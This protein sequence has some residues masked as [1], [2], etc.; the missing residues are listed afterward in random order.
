MRPRWTQM[1]SPRS[2]V[3]LFV[4]TI[5]VWLL[6]GMESAGR[7]KKK[8]ASKVQ[9][10]AANGQSAPP[11]SDEH[12]SAEA[13]ASQAV[14]QTPSGKPSQTDRGSADHGPP[15]GPGAAASLA[16]SGTVTVL[17]PV[18]GGVF[19]SPE[20]ELKLNVQ[21]L[22]GNTLL[23]LKVLVDGRVATSLRGV[24]LSAPAVEK[25][26]LPITH[27]LKVPVPPHDVVLSVLA[28]TRPLKSKPATVRLRWNG[29]QQ[30]P[31]QLSVLQP[32]LYLLSIGVSD[33]QQKELALRFAAKDAADIAAAF[34]AQ[35]RSLY[36]E[37]N[38]RTL[39]NQNATKNN[40]L[41]GLEW[42]Q[43]QTTAKDIAVL[44][45]AGHGV[46]DPGTGAYYFLPFDADMGSMKRT[47]IPESEIR[48]TLASVAGKVILFL[49]SCH[50]GKVFS[51]VQTRGPADLSAFLGELA[52]AENGVVV[53]AA[54]TGRQS[55]QESVSWN[56]G[57]FTKALI[58]GLSGR[59]DF[60]K[61]GRVTINMLDLYVS[62]R[63]KELTDGRQTPTTAKPASIPDF[64]L[65]VTREIHNEDI[66]LVR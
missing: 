36:R 46:T 48:D 30:S 60:Q 41:D 25:T 3:A 45:L 57:A 13:P 42:L 7:S 63:V 59:A 8:A 12:A 61:S 52:S 27:S 28:D 47:M 66:D 65:T 58:E 26:G 43:R 5:V 38:A 21:V 22:D 44:F 11:A 19:A 15:F 51:G 49:D 10:T 31:E 54:S 40:V 50:S 39:V 55:S 16:E 17:A 37:V 1:F 24:T 33:Y 64:P 2:L 32:K 14:N 18:D 4:V 53:F 29:T 20:V 6:P 9:T 56:N 62:E 34:R 23:G 35:S